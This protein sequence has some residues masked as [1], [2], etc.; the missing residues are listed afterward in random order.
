MDLIEVGNKLRFGI[1]WTITGREG[2]F[3]FGNIRLWANNEPIG[4]F[5]EVDLVSRVAYLFKQSIKLRDKRFDP[6]LCTQDKALVIE[7]VWNAVYGDIDD[8]IPLGDGIK[9]APFN[10]LDSWADG[11]D[12]YNAAIVECKNKQRFIWKNRKT[13]VVKESILT[14]GE[15][16]SVAN[17]FINWMEKEFGLTF[18]P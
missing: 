15:Y 18:E 2:T 1:E 9:Y 6:D 4:D 10:I 14:I 3:V 17:E 13:G 16:E 8:E 11:F 12:N 5:Q 7:K